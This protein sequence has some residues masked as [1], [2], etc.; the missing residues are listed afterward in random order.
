MTCENTTENGPGSQSSQ[1]W[2]PSYI[3][4]TPT[5]GN[6]H[7]G[8]RGVVPARAR[9]LPTPPPGAGH[10]LAV[11]VDPNTLYMA[12]PGDMIR[13]EDPGP[14]VSHLGRL[15][16]WVAG[17]LPPGGGTIA[18]DGDAADM[19][20]WPYDMERPA[21]RD[22]PMVDRP[23]CVEQ[24]AAHGWTTRTVGG[25]T[26]WERG[27]RGTPAF[28]SVTVACLPW[29]DRRAL[30]TGAA[31]LLDA[32]DDA[33]TA[34]Y[35]LARVASLVGVPF[36][37]T[38]GSTFAMAVRARFYDRHGQTKQLKGK[39]RRPMMRLN[40]DEKR[41]PVCP[42]F[43]VPDGGMTWRRSGATTG[44][45]HEARHVMGLDAI[46][47]HLGTILSGSFGVDPL[48]EHAAVEFDPRIPGL[49]EL[50][51]G[52]FRLS[53]DGPGLAGPASTPAG[54]WWAHTET[55]KLLIEN[56]L[57]SDVFSTRAWVPTT[58]DGQTTRGVQLL[59]PLGERIRDA[60]QSIPR[61]TADYLEKRVRAALKS[62]YAEAAG[63]LT[64]HPF[65]R[66]PDWS[67]G[68]WSGARAQ[69]LRRAVRVRQETGTWP[70][71][72]VHDCLYYET[73]GIGPDHIPAPTVLK[74]DEDRIR[75]GHVKMDFPDLEAGQVG[76]MT[77][78]IKKRG[79]EPTKKKTTRKSRK[80]GR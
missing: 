60:I 42:A 41:G 31:I 32:D 37:Y 17:V 52:T 40:N 23:R 2:D 4:G 76:T 16:D 43:L 13:T 14:L 51:G 21:D 69:T 46:G 30:G 39:S 74:Y 12:G 79:A 73:D 33:G 26:T 77:E 75:L 59:R 55:V 28:S 56:G 11:T 24:A 15:L 70:I 57:H 50:Q 10:V 71:E 80:D 1:S 78:Y 65:V 29:M 19:L 45:D 27:E 62:M 63:E 36:A 72:I 61:D 18:V 25:W 34:S 44:D 64:R 38:A 5:T 9:S 6:P 54:T 67:M 49:W 66:R 48:A 3:E 8:T 7:E 68:I 58:R 35:L 53:E 22:R 20:G 47:Q